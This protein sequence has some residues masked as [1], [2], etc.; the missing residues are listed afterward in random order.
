MVLSW[1]SI[2][3]ISLFINVSIDTILC[4]SLAVKINLNLVVQTHIL[5]NTYTSFGT[6]TSGNLFKFLYLSD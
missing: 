3:V 1:M 5:V 4:Q 6:I 2:V